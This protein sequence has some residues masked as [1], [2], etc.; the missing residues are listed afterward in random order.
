MRD[1]NLLDVVNIVEWK[2]AASRPAD[3]AALPR[4]KT[5][6]LATRLLNS[7]AFAACC[8][9]PESL[10]ALLALNEAVALKARPPSPRLRVV[11]SSSEKDAA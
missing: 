2:G 8:I 1:C 6:S 3:P 5:A 4:P 11:P 9:Y 7:F 10:V